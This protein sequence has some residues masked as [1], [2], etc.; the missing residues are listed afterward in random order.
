MALA[1]AEMFQPLSRSFWTRN[2]RS[3]PSLKSRR[4]AGWPGVRG[5]LL[6]GASQHGLQV[7]GPTSSSCAMISSRST[8][9]LSSRT[10]PRQGW[11]A[12]ASTASWLNR[13][14]VRCSPAGTVARSARRAAAMSSGRSRSGGTRDRDH[15][16]PEEQV[17]AKGALVDLLLEV[18]VGGGDHAHVDL[19]RLLR[20]DPLDLALLQ[21]AQQLRLRAQAHVA[22]LVEEERAAVGL[23]ELAD[24]LR[25]GAGERALLVAEQLALDQLLGDRR[26]VDL[27][28]GARRARRLL[29]WMARATSSLPTPLS[30]R[31]QH[32]G[33]G[34]RRAPHG[35]ADPRSAGLVA[36]HAVARLR[37]RAAA[38]GSP[39]ASCSWAS[40][41]RTASRMR[42][43][44]SG[45]SMKSKAPSL[46]GLDRGLDRAVARDHHDRAAL[47]PSPE[48]LQHLEPVELPASSRRGTRG[49]APPTPRA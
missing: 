26:A 17:L 14:R 30:P 5:G 31:D 48:P 20:A 6:G 35:L 32:G 29:R 8:A 46:R 43:L 4:V 9:F 44:S 18:L 28:E 12:S 42:S 23:L 11:R 16:Q 2:A 37:A 10:L 3:A 41:L 45:F 21:H 36:H 25:G 27:H 15:V 47:E 33:A 24:L 7:S 22:D 38:C 1:V 49:R 19:D 13:A 34:R 40:A 39:R